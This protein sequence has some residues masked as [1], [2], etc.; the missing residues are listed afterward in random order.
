[1]SLVSAPTAPTAPTSVLVL[2]PF[3]LCGP[4]EGAMRSWCRLPVHWQLGPRKGNDADLGFSEPGENI[5]QQPHEP[6]ANGFMPTPSPAVY[7]T[8]KSR[9]VCIL[10]VRKV[11]KVSRLHGS[12]DIQSGLQRDQTSPPLAPTDPPRNERRPPPTGDGLV[13]HRLGALGSQ[14]L[15]QANTGPARQTSH[16]CEGT[17]GPP[18]LAGPPSACL[19]D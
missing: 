4:I 10:C 17:S 7:M 5:L 15:S 1:M 9:S 16:L 2:D 12:S 11:G 13:R 6:S 3:P 19:S 18:R 14:L 8:D